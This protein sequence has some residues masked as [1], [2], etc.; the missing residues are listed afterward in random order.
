VKIS[1]KWVRIVSLEKKL[2]K[3]IESKNIHKIENVFEEIYYEYGKLVGFIISKYVIKKEDIEELVDDVFINFSKIIYKTSIDNIKYYLVTQAKNTSINFIQK[4]AN[5]L[6]LIYDET[7]LY[8]QE[9]TNSKYYELI[10]EMKLV[11]ND[12][13]INIILL[14]VVY[15]YTFDEIAIKLSKPL[16]SIA[17][18]YR[19]AIKKFNK[20]VKL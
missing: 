8:E 7:L 9:E 15:N 20:E 12:I 3:A 6:D 10:S 13:E 14:H 5:K 11:L 18:T 16:S 2:Q 4:K 1:L 19:R 17:S